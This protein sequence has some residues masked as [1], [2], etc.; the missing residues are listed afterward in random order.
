MWFNRS[1]HMSLEATNESVN[2]LKNDTNTLADVSKL[3]ALAVGVFYTLGL[4]IV[5]L[6]LARYGILSLELYRPE[7]VLVG[8]LWT[9]LLL[10]PFIVWSQTTGV[11]FVAKRSFFKDSPISRPIFFLVGFYL[12][13][14]LFME[15]I[16]D[17]FGILTLKGLIPF[18]VFLFSVVA[19]FSLNVRDFKP[20]LAQFG[21][22]RV[23][24]PSP[25]PDRPDFV[26]IPTVLLQMLCCLIAYSMLVFPHLRREFGGGKPTEIELVL[27]EK[28]KLPWA[29]DGLP[30]SSDGLTIGPA[31]LLMETDKTVVITNVTNPTSDA[32]ALNKDMVIAYRY[33]SHGTHPT[34]KSN[35]G[36]HAPGAVPNS[37]YASPTGKAR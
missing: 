28:T 5:N 27:S 20:F 16:S 37:V 1:K 25:P 24:S 13:L 26:H 29:T 9:F 6:N 33:I 11:L 19:F 17:D 14:S 23:A 3:L 30:V 4:L 21:I 18:T 7:Y 15:F 10:L 22:H 2:P 35:T 36:P 8:A 31:L 32:F 12:S 34:P